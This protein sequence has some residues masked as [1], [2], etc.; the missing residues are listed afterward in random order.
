[1]QVKLDENIYFQ[2]SGDTVEGVYVNER[3][4]SFK[5]GEKQLSEEELIAVATQ[6]YNAC[7]NNLCIAGT[8]KK[9]AEEYERNPCRD[10][11]V[12]SLL[13]DTENI[14]K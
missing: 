2:Q 8:I 9:I 1:M 12:L 7:K 11:V 4:V 6:M 14:K 3:F 13:D 10:G 5:V